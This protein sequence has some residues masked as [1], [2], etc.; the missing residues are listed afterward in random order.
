M[1]SGRHVG[2]KEVRVTL[3]WSA[4]VDLDLYVTDPA[5]ETVYFANTPSGSGGKLEHDT[6]CGAVASSKPGSTRTESVHWDRP[7]TGQ[8]RIGVD[9]IDGCRSSADEVSFRIAVDLGD[10]RREKVGKIAKSRFEPVILEFD[11]PGEPNES[12]AAR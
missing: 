3:A 4:D 12:R 9:F 6:T 2:E 1:P 10:R 7:P 11:V 5:Q 8:Y